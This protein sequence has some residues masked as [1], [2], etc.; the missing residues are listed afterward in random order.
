MVALGVESVG[1]DDG[2]FEVGVVDLVEQGRE[3]GYFVGLRADLAGGEGDPVAVPDSGEYED[4]AAVRALR[5][6]QALAVHRDGPAPAAHRFGAGGR[7]MDPALFAFDAAV[8]H[9]R[10]RRAGSAGQQGAKVVVAGRADLAGIQAAQNG[11]QGLLARDPVAAKQ[12]VI[13]QAEG[14]QLLGGR[15]SAP[16]RRRGDRVMTG[17]C[18]RAD[19]QGQ[20]RRD[21]IP[22]PARPTRIGDRLELGD[23]APDLIPR[24]TRV[25]GFQT[26][27][28]S[29]GSSDR[30]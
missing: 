26:G 3:L 27:H 22:H 15:T 18:H 19:H 13:G 11:A 24:V 14:S 6:A 21:P 28:R 4:A 29:D 23:E 5:A 9:E 1:G 16:L 12:W 2:P 7:P 17:R 25:E 20:Q 8:G 10:F 30:G